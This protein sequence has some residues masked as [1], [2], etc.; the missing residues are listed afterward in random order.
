MELV[1]LHCEFGSP[2]SAPWKKTPTRER[3]ELLASFTIK[4]G[5]RLSR[6]GT[7]PPPYQR[8]IGM[9]QDMLLLAKQGKHDEATEMLKTLRQVG[10]SGSTLGVQE[11]GPSVLFYNF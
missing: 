8:R 2:L 9:I 10:G 11:G 4:P 6:A 3:P 5:E 1:S 7:P